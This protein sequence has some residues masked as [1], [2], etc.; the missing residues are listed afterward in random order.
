MPLPQIPVRGMR[1][2]FFSLKNRK[3]HVK[4]A[5]APPPSDSSHRYEGYHN[6]II[7]E[8]HGFLKDRM[9]LFFFGYQIKTLDP[10]PQFAVS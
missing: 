3:V 1:Y 5:H 2:H 7:K 10:D 6:K 8:D 9:P 4:R